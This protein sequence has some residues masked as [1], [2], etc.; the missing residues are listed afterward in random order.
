[1][2]HAVRHTPIVC[3]LSESELREREAT[4]L[5]RFK[6]VVAS[7]EELVDGYL[8]RLPGDSQTLALIT[9]LM[10]AERQ[11]CPFLTFELTAWPNLG[12][13]ELL[14]VGPNGSKDFLK[15]RFQPTIE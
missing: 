4:L 12:C 10:A 7:Q 3:R 5:A 2:D 6:A 14:I 15:A 13:L 8:F 11:C 1:V 9:E